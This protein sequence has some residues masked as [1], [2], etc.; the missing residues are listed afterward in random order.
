M[1]HRSSACVLC[2]FAALFF[3]AGPA[4]GQSLAD[5]ARKERDRR[6][7]AGEPNKVYT[8]ADLKNLPPL[9]DPVVTTPAPAGKPGE[10]GV[11]VPLPASGASKPEK[12]PKD[13][14]HWRGRLAAARAAL[15]TAELTHSAL[16]NRVDVLAADF[17]NRDD[18]GQKAVIAQ[19]R[20]QALVGFERARLEIQKLRKEIA[21]IAIGGAPPQR[22][23]G[24]GPVTSVP[25]PGPDPHRRRQRIAA[26]DAAPCASR[27]R[28]I[29]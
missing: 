19:E 26:H 25:S 8:N 29:A 11:N 7:R 18:P 24:L 17:V 16:Q 6:A 3:V 15:E 10:P 27:R 9:P 20:Q 4:S 12:D 5:M 21:D 13:E 1:L 2:F 23:A 22:A 14:A 28:A